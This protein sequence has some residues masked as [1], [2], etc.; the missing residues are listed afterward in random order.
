MCLKRHTNRGKNRRMQQQ[1]DVYEALVYVNIHVCCKYLCVCRKA[2]AYSQSITQANARPVHSD[3]DRE[4]MNA[5]RSTQPKVVVVVVVVFAMRAYGARCVYTRKRA[6][7]RMNLACKH[8]Q[9]YGIR[10]AKP[11]T[12]TQTHSHTCR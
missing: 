8:T 7:D 10:R 3:P 4:T 9:I 12:H 1:N 6:R 2:H 11:H 5:S